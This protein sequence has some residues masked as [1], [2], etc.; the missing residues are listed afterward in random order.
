[1]SRDPARLSLL[2]IAGASLL[3]LALAAI[4]D[5]GLDEAYTLAVTQRLQLSWFDHPPMAF[6]IAGLMQS[7]FGPAIPPVLLR[8]PF[9]ALAAATAWLLFRLVAAHFDQRAA[10]WTVGLFLAAPF[11]FFS[12]GSWVVPDGPLLFFIT[13]CAL[14][15]TPI[16]RDE[17]RAPH[18]RAWLLAGA[19]LGGALLSKYHAAVFGFGVVLWFVLDHRLRFWFARPQ[20]YV[21]VLVAALVF[22]PVVL[23]NAANDWASFGFQFGRSQSAVGATPLN[24]LRLTLFE[25]GYLLPTTAILLLVATGWALVRRLPGAGFFLTVGLPLVVVF[26]L[27]RLWTWQGYAHWAMPGWMLLLPLAGALLAGWPARWRLLT[28]AATLVQF[29]VAIGAVVLLLSSVH[30]RLPT[31]DAARYE[32]GSWRGVA[33]AVAANGLLDDAP[34]LVAPNWIEAA[35][36]AEAFRAGRPVLVFG[37]DRRGFAVYGSGEVGRDALIF[38]IGPDDARAGELY[39]ALFERIEPVGVYPLEAGSTALVAVSRGRNLLQPY[40]D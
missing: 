4:T 39:G 10:L 12:A 1:M 33:V 24:A 37:P 11:F 31:L 16:L 13:A 30:L 23:W 22:T 40:A 27:P 25:F 21:A 35:R 19:M 14:A 18:W 20:P 38:T 26:D 32:A 8:L 7:L 9:I 36:V 15:L 28:A 5:L 3:R 2:L 29:A 34:M 17:T 6:W